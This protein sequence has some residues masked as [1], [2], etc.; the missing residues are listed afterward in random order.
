MS[1]NTNAQDIIDNAIRGTKPDELTEG[2]LYS[3][4]I[5]AGGTHKLVD[6]DLDKY[7][8]H[9]R[10][11]AGVVKLHDADTFAKY[12]GK[13]GLP[14]TEIYADEENA[15][16][17][18]VINAHMGTTG[19]GIEDFA[20]WADHRALL[21]VKPTLSWEAWKK[22]N[23][24]F[25]SQVEFAEHI[26]D[27]AIDILKPTGAEMLEVAQSITAKIGVAFESSQQLSTGQRKFEFKETIGAK[28]GERGQ[29]EIPSVI[30][31]GLV[32]FQGAPAYKV[33]ARFRYRISEGRL[34]LAYALER[35]EDVLRNA[36][37]D[38]VSTISG[39]IDQPIFM[40]W[41]E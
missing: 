2:G 29:L 15:R 28:A 35:P 18:A 19:D 5:P 9:P 3:V 8:D 41:P 23:G 27:R 10:R 13:H 7:R 21:Q 38:V 32:P 14:Q 17:V 1:D 6:L 25:I 12:V 20:G 4:V 33:I 36:F 40:G 16:I 11:K 30:E 34:T 31:L 26:E 39:D 24:R 22:Y 37:A